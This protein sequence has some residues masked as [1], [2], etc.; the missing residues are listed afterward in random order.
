[1]KV[2][3]N[4]FDTLLHRMMQSPPEPAK[5]IETEGIKGSKAPLIPPPSTPRKA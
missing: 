4:K 3:K 2:D 5:G 1:M